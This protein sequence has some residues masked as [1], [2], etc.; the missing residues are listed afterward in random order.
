[1]DCVIWLLWTQ[2]KQIFVMSYYSNLQMFSH[3]TKKVRKTENLKATQLNKGNENI[4]QNR[5]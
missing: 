2:G 5:L 3:S 4:F 1:M